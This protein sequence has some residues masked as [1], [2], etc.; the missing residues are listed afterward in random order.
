LQ[1]RHA[2][3]EIVEAQRHADEGGIEGRVVRGR[4]VKHDE[5]AVVEQRTALERV[6]RL[7]RGDPRDGDALRRDEPDRGGHEHE[8]EDEAELRPVTRTARRL[9]RSRGRGMV[10]AIDEVRHPSAVSSRTT[11]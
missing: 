10:G 3:R 4:A 2:G 11:L 9:G 7:V 5:R 8:P 6:D 1:Q